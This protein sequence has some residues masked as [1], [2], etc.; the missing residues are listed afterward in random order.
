[1][2]TALAPRTGVECLLATRVSPRVHEQRSEV[3]KG[4]RRDY[5]EG[6]GAK[7]G[8]DAHPRRSRARSQKYR[9]KS[10]AQRYPDGS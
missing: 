9:N 1:M 7:R 2:N 6:L 10:A 8:R 3:V 4:F 5:Q